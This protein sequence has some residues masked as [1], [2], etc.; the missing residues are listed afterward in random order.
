MKYAN[1][2]AH[3]EF[4]ITPNIEAYGEFLWNR[5]DSEQIGAGQIFQSFAQLTTLYGAAPNS[6]ANVL[7]ASNPNNPFGQN[8]TTTTAYNEPGFGKVGEAR[9]GVVNINPNSESVQEVR[10]AVNN[11]SAEHGGA[12]GG[13]INAVTRS[14]TNRFKGTGRLFNV[15][16]AFQ[17]DNITDEIRAQGGG[18]GAPIR[19]RSAASRETCACSR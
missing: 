6:V 17:A 1:A 7:P 8:V 11:F 9:S 3:L 4:D 5:R 15:N 13:V 16:D 14:G 18:S 2:F 10:I 19:R 12:M